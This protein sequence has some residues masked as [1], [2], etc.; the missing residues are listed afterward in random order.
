MKKFIKKFIIGVVL[1]LLG[2]F[3][4]SSEALCQVIRFN[5][6]SFTSKERT[7]YGWSGW[8]KKSSS[9][10]LLTI[11]LDSDLVTIYS[12]RIQVYKIINYDGAWTDSDGDS[13]VQY[14]FIDQDGDYGTLRLVQ[15]RNGLSEVYIDFSN[16]IWV[17]SVVRLY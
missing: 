4:T 11:D 9:D 1:L 6:T 3:I 5:T 12:P 13:T 16:I 14:K 17:Y 10:M 2:I 7:S 15:R 8:K